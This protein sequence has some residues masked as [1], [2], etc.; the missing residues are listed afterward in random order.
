MVST[1]PVTSTPETSACRRR[2]TASGPAPSRESSR[3]GAPSRPA[4]TATL[5][6]LPP[7]PATYCGAEATDGAGERGRTAA[8]RGAGQPGRRSPGQTGAAGDAVEPDPG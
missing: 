1:N 6:A 4:A 5:S 3:T 7:G 8:T 2:L